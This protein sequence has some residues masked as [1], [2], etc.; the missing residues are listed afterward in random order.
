VVDAQARAEMLARKDGRLAH[1]ETE[2]N[3]IYISK[4][5]AELTMS[6]QLKGWDYVESVTNLKD[7]DDLPVKYTQNMTLGVIYPG[8]VKRALMLG[9][10]G[11]SIST[12][13]ARYMPELTL[14]TVEIDPGVIAATKKYFGIRATEKV[15]YLEGDGRVFLNR[16]KDTYDLILV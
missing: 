3:D 9:L 6:F 12:Y 13:L 15:R 11:G 4:Q 8:D 14:D 16:H 2:Y 5:R 1:I 10:G 7:A